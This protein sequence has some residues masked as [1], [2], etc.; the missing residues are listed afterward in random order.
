M[1][2]VS[3]S[4]YNSSVGGGPGSY[5]SSVHAP[6]KPSSAN[7]SAASSSANNTNNNNSVGTSSQIKPSKTPSTPIVP[8]KP[9]LLFVIVGINEPLYEAE[10]NQH[11]SSSTVAA[12]SITRQNYFV[13]HSALD[14]ADRATW[15]T[16][17]MFLKVVD[18]VG[19]SIIY[20]S[21]KIIV[22]C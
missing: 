11:P 14:L 15:T 3:S 9:P 7:N 20:D 10:L 13:L 5:G 19:I 16:N 21:K 17:Q 1:S 22:H 8:A 12:D 18:K 2:S 6:G 4:I